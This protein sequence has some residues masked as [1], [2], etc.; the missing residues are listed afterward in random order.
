MEL[1]LFS[2]ALLLTLPVI[3][4]ER[5][6]FNVNPVP[7]PVIFGLYCFVGWRRAKRSGWLWAAKAVIFA[8]FVLVF[9]A[10]VGSQL[11]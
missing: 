5:A 1:A 9:A 4:S 3:A 10:M 11:P 2:V 6:G 7:G 8:A